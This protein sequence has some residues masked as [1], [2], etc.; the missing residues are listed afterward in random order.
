[1]TFWL[2]PANAIEIEKSRR[3]CA[4]SFANFVKEAWHI[5]EP[6]RELKWGWALDA[7]CQHL[8]AVHTGDILRLL[9]NVPPGSMKSLLTNVFFPAWEWG[10]MG[11]PDLRYLGTAHKVDLARRDN[12]KC[13]RLIKS[14]WYQSRWRIKLLGDQDAK[15]KF[16]NESTGF[17]ECMAF[18]SLTGSRGDRVSLDDPH[19]VNSANSVAE[20]D[21]AEFTFKEALPSRVND[22]LSAI[23][24]I[25]QRLHARDVSGIILDL[26]LPYEH[27]CLPMEFEES[28]R[29][30][31]SIGFRDPRIFEGQLL[32]PE[33]FSKSTVAELKLS[34]G[35]V[36]A[37]GQLQQRPSP[38]EGN[39]FKREWF[40]ETRAIPAGSTL[41]RGWDLAAT[42]DPNAPYTAG[43][44]L[45]RTPEKRFIICG[46]VRDQ[47]SPGGVLKLI[48]RTAA[49]DGYDVKISIPQDPGQA[50]KSQALNFVAELAG[51][52]VVTSTETGDKVD[53]AEP[54]S[55]QA[56]GGNLDI[57]VT[58]DKDV[59]AWIKPFLDEICE[60]PASKFKDQTD[61]LSRAFGE[62]AGPRITVGMLLGT[63]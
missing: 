44:L 32:F 28:R 35:S 36:G 13:R 18:T 56:E 54:V 23:I 45:A 15:D 14:A 41:C 58:G 17:R 2:P 42:A 49:L 1:M 3:N 38:R 37:A 27:L 55:A 63:S 62:I 26:G 31:T 50:G 19:S 11:R 43:V 34:L 5:V 57:L 48:K 8:E 24:V 9:M 6:T 22:D 29:C 10:P 25:M 52:N 53:R 21:D 20:L 46:A 60:F 12:V 16:E 40:G 33:R 61:A 7:V 4:R 30:F 39:L 59:D 47:L 51:F